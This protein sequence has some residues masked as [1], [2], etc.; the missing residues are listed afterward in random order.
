PLQE[1]AVPT[2][3]RFSQLNI[4]YDDGPFPDSSWGAVDLSYVGR[5]EPLYFNLVVNGAWQVRNIPVLSHEGAGRRQRARI[6]F[7]LQTP[8]GVDV[9]TL[10]YA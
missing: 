4:D 8:M 5:E 1:A 3:L 9:R 7:D 2:K 10:F 6:H